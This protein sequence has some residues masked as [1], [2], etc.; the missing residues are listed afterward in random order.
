VE[1][2]KAVEKRDH[3][4]KGWKS[5]TQK[6]NNRFFVN[7][8]GQFRQIEPERGESYLF[9][10]EKPKDAQGE[11]SQGKGGGRGTRTAALT[12]S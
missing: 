2:P 10:G 6:G 8:S 5:R 3:G 7:T 1:V 4:T 9:I 11:G 12:Y